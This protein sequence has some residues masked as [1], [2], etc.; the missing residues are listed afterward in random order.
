MSIVGSLGV[1]PTADGAMHLAFTVED[2]QGG[3]M[4]VPKVSVQRL[5][6]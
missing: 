6:P 1:A 2:S 5:S 4:G 3:A